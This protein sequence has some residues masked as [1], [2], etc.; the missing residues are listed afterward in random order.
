M[1]AHYIEASRQIA[2]EVNALQHDDLDGTTVD[3]WVSHFTLK[4]GF[5]PI[6]LL[7]QPPGMRTRVMTGQ[8]P[9]IL[10]PVHV[11]QDIVRIGLPVEPNP[12]FPGLL[13]YRGNQYFTLPPVTYEDGCLFF[14]IEGTTE[15]AIRTRIEHVKSN[16]ASLNREIARGNA[17]LPSSIRSWIEGR[18]ERVGVRRQAILSL[19]EALGAE[20]Q[21]TPAAQRRAMSVP[22]V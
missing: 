2:R 22:R 3:Q 11:D 20:L 19:A 5:T 16:V 1:A 13:D 4:Y 17:E 7:P 18:M 15:A 14:E 12:N 6:A 10:G 8:A 9:G 21:L